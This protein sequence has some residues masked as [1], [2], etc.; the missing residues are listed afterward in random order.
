MAQYKV[1]F[2][3]TISILVDEANTEQEAIEKAAESEDENAMTISEQF[4]RVDCEEEAEFI[5]GERFCGICGK[6]IPEDTSAEE[7][8]QDFSSIAHMKCA[9]NQ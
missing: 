3:K 7:I 2:T 1:V 5:S 9:Q 6:A 4:E 8:Q